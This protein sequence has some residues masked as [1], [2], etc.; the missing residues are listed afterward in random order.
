MVHAIE[1][2]RSIIGSDYC[3]GN[4]WPLEEFYIQ[5]K[6]LFSLTNLIRAIEI[7]TP[8]PNQSAVRL[9]TTLTHNSGKAA[10]AL[11][12]NGVGEICITQPELRQLLAELTR[13][14][15]NLFIR[16]CLDKPTI[17]RLLEELWSGNNLNDALSFLYAM[18]S[19]DFDKALLCKRGIPLALAEVFQGQVIA[20]RVLGLVL[21]DPAMSR[22]VPDSI[23][24]RMC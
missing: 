12:G 19:N 13:Y 3:K 10:S 11:I 8:N 1:A 4:L 21:L 16:V 24:L 18:L 17:N 7:N 9:L 15:A 20:C 23:F 14:D 2:L 22:D 5:E 6:L